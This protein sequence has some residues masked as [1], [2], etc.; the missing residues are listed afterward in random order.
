MRIPVLWLRRLHAALTILWLLLIV[1]TLLWWRHSVPWLL[2]VSI[3]AIVISHAT[4]WQAARA[5]DA[6]D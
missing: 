4:A 6:A 3:Y 5:E 1:P 2:F